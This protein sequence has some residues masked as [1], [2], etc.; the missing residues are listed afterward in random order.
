MNNHNVR[1]YALRNTAPKFNFDV[2]ISR[3]KVSVWIGL[4]GSRAV[5][6]QI[7]FKSNFSG[8]VYLN[9]L[10]EQIIPELRQIHG[11]RMNM[12]WCI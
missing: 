3:E 2:G 10:N 4:C 12:M 7:C 6:G 8:N 1:H 11:N 5:I 9:I